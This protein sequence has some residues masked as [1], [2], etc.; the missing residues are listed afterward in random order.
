MTM[1]QEKESPP[2]VLTGKLMDKEAEARAG[3]QRDFR[4][5]IDEI[6][7]KFDGQTPQLTGRIEIILEAS[8]NAPL[9]T[10]DNT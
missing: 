3:L 1:P 8:D 6:E 10:L 2:L 4:I 9:V 5:D 7:I